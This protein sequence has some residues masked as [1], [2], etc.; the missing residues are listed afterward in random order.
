[1]RFTY[2]EVAKFEKH[3]VKSHLH[4]QAGYLDVFLKSA[5]SSTFKNNKLKYG[6]T[7]KHMV[8]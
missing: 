3:L 2:L 7:K 1:M 4:H 8:K 6:A 5:V